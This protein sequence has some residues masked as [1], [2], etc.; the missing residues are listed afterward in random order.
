MQERTLH[1]KARRREEEKKFRCLPR[2]AIGFF[3]RAF[4]EP[5]A[6]NGEDYGVQLA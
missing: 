2:L 4:G 6:F 3:L 1:A 5:M